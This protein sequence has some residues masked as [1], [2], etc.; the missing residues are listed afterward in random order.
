MHT[1]G[2]V[3]SRFLVSPRERWLYLCVCLALGAAM[4]ATGHALEI[5]AFKYWWQVGTC[6]LGWV[7]LSR[8]WCGRCTRC[9]S[10]RGA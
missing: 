10:S 5:A 6:Y 1:L 8:C 4:N 3:L 9:G 7:F 2:I